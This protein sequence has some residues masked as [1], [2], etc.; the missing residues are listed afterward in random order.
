[1]GAGRENP[2]LTTGSMSSSK[3]IKITDLSIDTPLDYANALFCLS[4]KRSLYFMMLGR[5]LSQTLI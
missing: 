3:D 1:M 2:N 4:N 5:F